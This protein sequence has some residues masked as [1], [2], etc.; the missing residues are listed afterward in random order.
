MCVSI[1][2]AA[3]AVSER[4]EKEVALADA[5]RA[6]NEANEARKNV[7]EFVERLKD[8]N[9]LLTSG[10]AHA[11]AG[12]WSAAI[13]DYMR[14]TELQ[15]N[16]YLIWVERASLYV[17]LGLWKLASADFAK[18]IDLGAPSDSFGWS[19][20][21]QL[22][23]FTGDEKRYRESCVQMLHGT[24]ESSDSRSLSAIR[25]CLLAPIPSVEP[26]ALAGLA[27]KCLAESRDSM[28]V[29]EFGDRPPPPP[30]KQNPKGDFRRPD[31]RGARFGPD[32]PAGPGRFEGHGGPPGFVPPSSPGSNVEPGTPGGLDGPGDRRGRPDRRGLPHGASLYVVG[33]AQ[34]RAGQLE[35]AIELLARSNTEDPRWPGRGI[36]FPV[37]AMAYQR[38]GRGPEARG[39]LVAADNLIHEWLEE[40]SQE[41][42]GTMPIPWFDWVEFLALYREAHTLITGFRP[43]DDP[44]LRMIDERALNVL[45]TSEVLPALIGY[46]KIV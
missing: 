12:R 7:E 45:R 24:N 39:A 5:V 8:A 46:P 42:V 19:G 23:W 35:R 14:A 30:R 6:R 15:P 43:P 17:R 21:P 26:A 40:I 9:L 32:R 1:W 13:I 38:A 18:A 41:P 44:R 20:V 36:S 28:P 4:N 25:C 33:W 29:R 16:Y 3:R 2:Q 34:Y 11:D 37:L 22:F 10:R 31:G 27:E